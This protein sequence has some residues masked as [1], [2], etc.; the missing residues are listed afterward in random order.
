[1]LCGDQVYGP[2]NELGMRRVN[3]GRSQR[4][5]PETFVKHDLKYSYVYIEV[6]RNYYSSNETETGIQVVI[7][8]QRKI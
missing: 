4:N 6:A 3:L 5:D 8:I 1:M 2:C 7:G